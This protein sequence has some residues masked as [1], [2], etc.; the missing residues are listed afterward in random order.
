MLINRRIEYRFLIASYL[1]P[2]NEKVAPSSK[3]VHIGHEIPWSQYNTVLIVGSMC[4]NM[5]HRF[6]LPIFSGYIERAMLKPWLAFIFKNIS[7][8]GDKILSQEQEQ[9]A[10][11]KLHGG[12]PLQQKNCNKRN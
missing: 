6:S 2:Q 5:L 7:T 1:A 4:R 3:L 11:P 12:P 9:A 10:Y 8:H